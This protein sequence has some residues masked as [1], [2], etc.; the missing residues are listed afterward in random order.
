VTVDLTTDRA[1]MHRALSLAREAAEAGEIPV[2]ALVVR[3]G[4]VLAQAYNLRQI[5]ADPTAHAERLALTLAGR[6]LGTWRLDG[7][8]LYATLE[9]CPM[10]AGAAVLARVGRV[11]FGATDPKA[12]ACVSRYRLADDPRFNHRAMIVGGVLAD[13]CAAI[14]AQFFQSRRRAP[15]TGPSAETFTTEGCLS[16]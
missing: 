12:G 9:P 13:E 14:L 4:R 3:D 15:R 11:V 7:C 16:G 2:G 5:L 8:T 1:F 6:S 10:C